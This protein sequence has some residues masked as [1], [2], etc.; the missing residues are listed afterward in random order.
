VYNLMNTISSGLP[1]T[2]STQGSPYWLPN[3]ERPRSRL[4]RKEGVNVVSAA[5]SLQ[6]VTVGYQC[7]CYNSRP[8]IGEFK[9]SEEELV[10]RG[11][12]N[13]YLYNSPQ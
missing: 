6:P 13:G 9:V 5:G 8:A 10:E 2:S 11:I 1:T 3:S 7:G 12:E 4:N